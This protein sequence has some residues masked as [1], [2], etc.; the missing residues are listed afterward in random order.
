MKKV[1]NYEQQEDGANSF[2][3]MLTKKFAEKSGLLQFY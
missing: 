1:K 3:K 2:R